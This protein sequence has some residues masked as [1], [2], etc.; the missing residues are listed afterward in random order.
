M[1]NIY[2]CQDG[3]LLPR[4]DSGYR[5]TSGVAQLMSCLGNTAI[6]HDILTSLGACA[7][8]QCWVY[9]VLIGNVEIRKSK[10]RP[11]RL[12]KRIMISEYGVTVKTTIY[13]YLSLVPYD[14]GVTA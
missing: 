12:L 7:L 2:V 8:A 9:Q 6:W 1:Y 3:R 14:Y 11:R 5:P 10:E 13:M 4:S